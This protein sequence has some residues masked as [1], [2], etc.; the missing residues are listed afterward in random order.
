MIRFA[1]LDDLPDVVEYGR[2]FH[3][4]SQQPFPY[5]EE[6]ATGFSAGLIENDAGCVL[7]S[8]HGFIGGMLAPAYC[9][10]AW[11]MAVELFWWAEKDGMRLLR[12][13]ES[14]AVDRGAQEVRMTS[15][16]ALPKADAI[17]RRKGFEPAEISYRKVI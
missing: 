10:P 17:L 3:A 13:F 11:V 14:W 6:A 5:S 1:T 12:A 7:L 16:A 8:D 4:M 15:L 9:A 2:R